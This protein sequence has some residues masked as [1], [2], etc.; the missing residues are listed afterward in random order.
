MLEPEFHKAGS[1]EGKRTRRI[2][3]HV[4]KLKPCKN[5]RK[6]MPV[7]AAADLGDKGILQKLGPSFFLYLRHTLSPAELTPMG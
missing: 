5:R 2:E 4:H 3:S 1:Q 7:L 6:S